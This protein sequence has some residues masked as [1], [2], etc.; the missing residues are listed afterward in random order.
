M[1]GRL[2][3]AAVLALGLLPGATRARA[4]V[5]MT[6]SPLALPIRRLVVAGGD[7]RLAQ[8]VIDREWGL[9]EDSTYRVVDVP[10]WKSEGLA[11]GLSGVVPGAGQVYAGEGSGWFYLLA[12]GAG[13]IGRAFERNRARQ[14]YDEMVRFVGDPTDSSSGFS[15]A[16]Y[17]KRTGSPPTD[18]ERLWAGDHDA[19][20]RAL[21][22]DPSYAQGF[23]GLLPDEQ[24]SH[25]SDLLA[26]HRESTR[27]ARI[28]EGVL[29]LNH[30]VSAID[31]LRAARMNNVPL[32]EQY[33][34]ELGERMRHGRAELRAAVVRRF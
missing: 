8:R 5:Q 29:M 17:T 19:Y 20:Y 34:L 4:D 26:Q 32:T 31:A 2:L 12:E 24:Y 27:D 33:H 23:D 11:F 25:Y 14:H 10:G 9:S 1:S 16:R 7:G 30:L 13:W 6:C 18:L 28:L 22:N 21:A 3:V 15:F